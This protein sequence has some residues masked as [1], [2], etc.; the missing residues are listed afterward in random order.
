[1]LSL[2]SIMMSYSRIREDWRGVA[3][4]LIDNARARDVVLYYRGVG[5]FATESY[6]N[7]LPGGNVNRPRAVE[8]IPGSEKWR[9]EISGAQRV[10]LVEYPANLDDV[11]MR[12]LE[13][14][15]H[16]R[17]SAAASSSFRAV[18]VTEFEPR[19]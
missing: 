16:S 15:L 13:A 6:R 7:W 18:T 3:N 5:S 14:E 8:V 12:T 2:V 9:D 1:V 11:M 10:W 19:K 17:Y 4:Y